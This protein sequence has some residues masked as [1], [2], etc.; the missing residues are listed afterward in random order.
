M[1]A[2]RSYYD[3]ITGDFRP[4]SIDRIFGRL[5]SGLQTVRYGWG[6]NYQFDLD[7]SRGLVYAVERRITSY[8]VCY[9]KLLRDFAG[10]FTQ[11]CRVVGVYGEN[12]HGIL[13]KE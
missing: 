2:I 8:N 7:R 11:N 6:D 1:Y 5:D 12:G 3:R 10:F 13:M 9:T 4:Y